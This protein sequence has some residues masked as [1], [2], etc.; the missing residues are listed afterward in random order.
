MLYALILNIHGKLTTLLFYY[1]NICYLEYS[2]FTF[3][4]PM[5]HKNV[6]WLIVVVGSQGYLSYFSAASI[7]FKMKAIVNLI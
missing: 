7:P 1:S 6:I 2:F 3:T 5:F 4:L